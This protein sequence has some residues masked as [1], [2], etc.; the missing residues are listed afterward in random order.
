MFYPCW[1]RDVMNNYDDDDDNIR[2]SIK[3]GRAKNKTTP[4]VLGKSP[5][6]FGKANETQKTQPSDTG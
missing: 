5:N 1:W 2:T 6:E 4:H 3:A